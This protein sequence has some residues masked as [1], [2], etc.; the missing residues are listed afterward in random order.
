MLLPTSAQNPPWFPTG[1]GI[2]EGVG[3][4]VDNLA[5]FTAAL[6]HRRGA[7]ATR[8]SFLG[9]AQH[10][11]P[12]KNLACEVWGLPATAIYRAAAG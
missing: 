11:Q 9:T 12:A 7:G 8:T 3:G 6:P 10:S 5:A 1:V 2:G 4:L